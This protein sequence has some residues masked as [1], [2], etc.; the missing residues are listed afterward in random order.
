M[1][2]GYCISV[3]MSG[4]P[5]SLKGSG[6]KPESRLCSQVPA[7]SW[8]LDAKALCNSADGK[9]HVF[10]QQPGNAVHGVWM[11]QLFPDPTPCSSRHHHREQ[12]WLITA[13]MCSKR[14]GMLSSLS[15]L[16]Q[17]KVSQ[18]SVSLF[19]E[20]HPQ[21]LCP[22]WHC[23]GLCRRPGQPSD[24]GPSFQGA[25][26]HLNTQRAAGSVQGASLPCCSSHAVELFSSA[27][28]PKSIS[29]L[30][31]RCA[32]QDFL[33]PF[34]ASFPILLPG[35]EQILIFP[36]IHF[37]EHIPFSNLPLTCLS[38]PPAFPLSPHHPHLLL[39]LLA[40][41][42]SQWAREQTSGAREQNSKLKNRPT[43]P[44]PPA[45]RGQACLCSVVKCPWD[46]WLQ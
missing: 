31:D 27:L 17:S 29:L 40:L 18:I 4:I 43:A 45:Q 6:D 24:F 23:T 3:L 19:P 16:S 9:P 37:K 36:Q 5:R 7:G 35:L 1:W 26:C 39:G 38:S 25:S 20:F 8:L 2:Q 14:R 22:R 44:E 30:S 15:A 41:W 46:F 32:Q 28:K 10:Q 12:H 21:K 11:E 34:P 42:H 33:P 13:S